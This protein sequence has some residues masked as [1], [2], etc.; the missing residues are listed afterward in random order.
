MINNFLTI[1][2]NVSDQAAKL[3]IV[4]Q[5]FIIFV[6]CFV[7]FF[8]MIHRTALFIRTICGSYI[9]KRNFFMSYFPINNKTNPKGYNQRNHAHQRKKGK[10]YTSG[11]HTRCK[12]YNSDNGDQISYS[13]EQFNICFFH[14]GQPRKALLVIS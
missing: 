8:N 5:I 1:V 7:H 4:N 11:N 6:R 14:N 3:R 9:E 12:P 10:I 13:F 2:I